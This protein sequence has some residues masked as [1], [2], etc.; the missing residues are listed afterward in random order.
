MSPANLEGLRL[1]VLGAEP[2]YRAAQVLDLQA[3][4][5]LQVLKERRLHVRRKRLGH[6]ELPGDDIGIQGHAAC[7]CHRL[8]LPQGVR[9]H[10]AHVGVLEHRTGRT[11]RDG[12]GGADRG[13]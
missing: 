13:E 5:R 8:G 12:V 4:A 2:R 1:A 11:A 7:P 3:F 9:E 10:P 6:A